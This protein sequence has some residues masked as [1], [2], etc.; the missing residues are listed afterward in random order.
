MFFVLVFDNTGDVLPFTAKHP[1]L[2]DYFIECITPLQNKVFYPV[3][4]TQSIDIYK[5]LQSFHETIIQINTWFEYLTGKK[6]PEVDA[7]DYLDQDRLN[8]MHALWVKSL[9][10]IYDINAQRNVKNYQGLVEKIHNDFSDD[11]RFPTLISVINKLG[12]SKEYFSIN[13]TIHPIECFFRFIRYRIKSDSWLEWQNP[14][15]HFV[16]NDISNLYLDFE[17]VGRTLENKYEFFDFDLEH[18]DEN[19]FNEILPLVG[20]N[21]RPPRTVPYSIEYSDWCKKQNKR[22]V[23]NFMPLGNIPNL[24]ENI[25]EFRIIVLRNLLS[26][27]G[28]T[29]HKGKN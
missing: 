20:L 19:S 5:K 16:S 9:S 28:F 25:K 15:K 4:N 23:G 21:L 2:L 14:F 6:Y 17:H 11:V 13:E 3:D 8:E 29:I 22:P 24:Y 27:N 10:W 1:D 7:L 26:G 12:L 18:D